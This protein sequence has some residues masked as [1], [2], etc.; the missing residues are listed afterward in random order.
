MSETVAMF[1]FLRIANKCDSKKL[2]QQQCLIKSEVPDHF[3]QRA[4]LPTAKKLIFHDLNPKVRQAWLIPL[5][6][7]SSN[8][9][10]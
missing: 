8:P 9:F 4:V 5:N 2:E 1:V 6:L 3:C 7:G 10:T